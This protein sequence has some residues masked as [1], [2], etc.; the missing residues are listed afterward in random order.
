MNASRKLKHTSLFL[1]LFA[2]AAVFFVLD[3]FVGS[4]SIPVK[5][6]FAVLLG[7]SDASE[8]IKTIIISFRLVGKRFANADHLP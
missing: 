7:I 4:L 1:L 5:Q 8:E 6:V 2:V 3:I